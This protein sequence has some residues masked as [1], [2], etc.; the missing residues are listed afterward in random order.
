MTEYK[1]IFDSF[2]QLQTEDFN[3]K[4]QKELTKSLDRY[5]GDYNQ[6]VINEIVLWKVNR[7]AEVDD[8]TLTLLN[9]ISPSSKVINVEEVKS[10]LHKLLRTKG[11]KL[12]MASTILRFKNPSLFQIIDQRVF[13]LLYNKELKLS[14]S[15]SE[16]N[17]DSQ[18]ALYFEYL[19]DLRKACEKL[20]ISFEDSDRV[21]F[22]A[23]RRVNTDH[24]L[25]NY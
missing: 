21:L 14:S 4:Y 7:Y 8:A 25:K 11:I 9:Q 12:A 23:D 18:I 3:F 20:S 19:V 2:F 16:R 6:S 13:R 5:Q 22:M 15:Q 1:T 17:I 10:L 24:K